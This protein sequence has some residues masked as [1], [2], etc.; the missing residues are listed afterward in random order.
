MN[1]YLYLEIAVQSPV[2]LLQLRWATQWTRGS[3]TFCQYW[4]CC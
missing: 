4:S 3:L 1:F 2:M